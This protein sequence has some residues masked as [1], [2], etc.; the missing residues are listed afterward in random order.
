M[1]GV[2][3]FEDLRMW[4]ASRKLA[5][6]VYTLT[7]GPPF[8]DASLRNQIRRAA[9]SVM[10][11]IAE[12]FG[13]GS[14]EEFLY[15]LFIAKG[16]LVEVQSQLYLSADLKYISRKGFEAAF[17]V[18]SETAKL[19]QAFAN[20]MKNVQTTGFRKK[21]KVVPWRDQVEQTMRELKREAGFEDEEDKK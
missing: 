8:K 1:A 5:N 13:R 16:S 19:I 3:K 14:N 6:L 7:G 4:Q 15:F 21:R 9:V 12:G 17:E 2:S 10:S 18:C 11:N 20:N